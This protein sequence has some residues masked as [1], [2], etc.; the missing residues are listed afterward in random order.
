MTGNPNEESPNK[1]V[2]K[3]KIEIA[4]KDEKNISINDK[5]PCLPKM[6]V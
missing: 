6:K 2:M 5:P 3:S 1:Y 4:E